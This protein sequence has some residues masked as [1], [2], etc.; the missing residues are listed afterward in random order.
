MNSQQ[1]RRQHGAGRRRKNGSG[2]M[3]RNQRAQSE[4][5]QESVCNNVIECNVDNIKVNAMLVSGE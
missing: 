4:H 2:V 1:G 3:K 5:L